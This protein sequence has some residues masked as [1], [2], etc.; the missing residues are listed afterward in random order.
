MA[1]V[2]EAHERSRPFPFL[3][4]PA[5]L[6]N[7]VYECMVL[8]QNENA[9]AQALHEER[10]AALPHL[11]RANQHLRYEVRPKTRVL[12]LCYTPFQHEIILLPPPGWYA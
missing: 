9:G 8:D 10:P 7:L 6:R 11:A 12:L 3:R 4:L 5:E 2:R 1:Q